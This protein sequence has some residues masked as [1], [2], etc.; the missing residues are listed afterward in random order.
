MANVESPASRALF[1]TRELAKS[2]AQPD[3]PSAATYVSILPTIEPTV[4][5]APKPAAP[6]KSAPMEDVSSPA[7]Q[8]RPN[9]TALA[10]I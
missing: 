5:P 3:K 9:V 7:P 6:V 1:V 10:A 8:G 2:H 4:V